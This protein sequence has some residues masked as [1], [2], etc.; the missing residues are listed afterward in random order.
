M[1]TLAATLIDDT[2]ARAKFASR[3]SVV[4]RQLSPQELGD[5]AEKMVNAPTES[6]ALE[7]QRQ[8]FEGFYGEPCSPRQLSEYKK[9][10]RAL[11]GDPEA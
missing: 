4:P 2:P 6:E 8:Y 10:A 9:Q 3:A 5:L 7:F 11:Y 1:L